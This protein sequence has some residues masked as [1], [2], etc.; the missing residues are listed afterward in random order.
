MFEYVT[1]PKLFFQNPNYHHAKISHAP[2][3][4]EFKLSFLAFQDSL[5]VGAHLVDS[6]DF[7]KERLVL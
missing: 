3:T 6:S 1:G 5:L 7:S 4:A 2:E